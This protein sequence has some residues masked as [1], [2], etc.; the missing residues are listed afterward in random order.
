MTGR[1]GPAELSALARLGTATL[2]EVAGAEARLRVID[3]AIAP[4]A[5]PGPR[6]AGHAFT[7]RCKPGDNLAIHLA[8]AEIGAGDT[9]VVDYGGSLDTG[10]FGEIMALAAQVRGAAGLVIDGAVRDRAEIAALGFGVW[11]RGLAIP[12]TAKADRG[13]VGAGCV[14]AGTEVRQGDLV[15]A[16]G[17][18]VIVVDPGAAAGL[19]ERGTERLTRE[20]TVMDRIRAGETT[21]EIFNLK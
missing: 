5:P 2:G 18:A 17:D 7:V 1:I 4:I 21:C 20:A 16:D 6:A 15:L 12:G 8:L 19:I 13:Q 10:P 14:I 3:R 11:A 9:L